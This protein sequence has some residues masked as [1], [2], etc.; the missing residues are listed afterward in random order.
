M[1]VCPHCVRRH[2]SS[3]RLQSA[4]LRLCHASELRR[5]RRAPGTRLPALLFAVDLEHY[6]CTMSA[7][8]AKELRDLAADYKA[9][10][11]S[12]H[13]LEGLEADAY[14]WR[15]AVAWQRDWWL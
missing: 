12:Q 9:G 6:A 3:V 14:H 5:A 8:L 7:A 4:I 1:E 13:D 10:I 2:T 15:G 11:Y